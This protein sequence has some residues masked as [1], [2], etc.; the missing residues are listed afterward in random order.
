MKK[1]EFISYYSLAKLKLNYKFFFVP[2]C[3][4]GLFLSVNAQKIAL[5]TP[6]KN[7]NTENL[8]SE[9]SEKLNTLDS[10]LV[11]NAF[12]ATTYE[13]IFNL[14]NDEAK[15]IGKTIGCDYFVLLKSETLR[16]SSFEKGDY[17]ESYAVIYLVSSKTGHLVFWKIYSFEDVSTEKS[18][19]KLFAKIE[20]ISKEIRLNIKAENYQ[21]PSITEFSETDKTIRSPL[22]FKRLKPTYTTLANF[23]AIAATVDIEIDLDEKGEIIR[24]EIVR[25]AGYGLDESVIENV[26]KMSWRPAEKDGKTLPIRVLLRYNFKKIEAEK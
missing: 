24:T 11:A 25:W 3:L 1:L 10:D 26:K 22:P 7:V 18:E 17:F 13:S 23:Y 21:K 15:V 19:A 12:K 4:C 14:S 16:R 20:D 9:L 5:I 2:L 8:S 6:Q